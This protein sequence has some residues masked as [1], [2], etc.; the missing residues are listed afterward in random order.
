MR[1]IA[2]LENERTVHRAENEATKEEVATLKRQVERLLKEVDN[3]DMELLIH[4]T[5]TGYA[6]HPTGVPP[7]PPQQLV[8]FNCPACSH[9]LTTY[10]PKDGKCQ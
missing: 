2:D 3:D 8:C 10:I 1:A 5:R 6:F 4:H 7:L 9:V